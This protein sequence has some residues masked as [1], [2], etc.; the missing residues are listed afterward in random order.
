M[1]LGRVP[2]QQIAARTEGNKT[3]VEIIQVLP[4]RDKANDIATGELSLVGQ[5]NGAR[6]NFH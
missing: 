2:Q 1:A 6:N 5:E 4:L 3:H